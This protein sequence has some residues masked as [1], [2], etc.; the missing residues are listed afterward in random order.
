MLQR[1]LRSNQKGFTLVELL[2]VVAILGILAAIIVPNVTGL[3]GTGEPE[4]A[5]AEKAI[6]QSAVD[7]MM[8]KN[9][10]STGLTTAATSDMSA[11]PTGYPLYPDY[12]RMATT[13]GTYSCTA[14]GTVTQVTT[15]YE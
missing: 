8:I 10:I 13:K 4:A 12:L 1:R 5:A 11:F 2:I 6:V 9:G 3:V 7:I 14:N 15:G